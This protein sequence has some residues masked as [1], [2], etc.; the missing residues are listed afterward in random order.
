M[1]PQVFRTQ[2]LV[3]PLHHELFLLYTIL[4]FLSSNTI[5][6]TSAQASNRSESD[7]QALLCFK[8]GISKGSARVL[9]SWRNDSLNFC[10]WRGVTCSTTLPIR[11]VSL[12]LRSTLLTGTLSS[13][14]AALN[15][16][17]QLD[18]WNN[19]L[20][21]SVPEEIG[22]LRSLQ[23]LMLAGNRLSGNI[24]LSL[25][26]AASL[27]SVNLAN[28]SLSGA[29]P[30]S[31]ANSS[32]LSEIILSR[33]N[34]SGG[35]P[36]NLF[37]SS[38]LAAVDLRSNALSGAIP[39]FQKTSALQFLDLTG[40][41]L[42]GTIPASLGNASSLRSLLLAQNKLA[43][44]IP[45]TIGQIP[46]LKRVDLSNNM[47]SGYVPAT[48]YNVSSLTF[49][50]L[51]S[52][53][54]T[55]QLPYDIGHSLP[56][57]ETLAMGLN[58]FRGSVPDSL[59][60]MS[61]LQVLDI[62]S[63]LLTG[64]VPS[65]GSL[66]NLSQLLLGD[67]KLEAD[68]WAFL[69]SLTNCTQL[70]ILSMD[71][72]ILNGSLPKAVGKL[73]TKLQR[74]SF[75]RNQISGNI[76]AEIG[77]LVSLALLDMGRNMLSGPIPLTVWNLS[78][79]VVLKLS[80][81]RLSGQIPS[82]VG[83]LVQ[84]SQLHLD[85]NELSGNI[86]ENIGQCK[87]LLMLNMSVN[88]L[89]GSIPRELFSISSLS[90]GLDLSNNNLTGPIPWEVSNLINLGLLDVS[91]N[92]LSGSLPSELG[93]CVQLL[94]LQI[95]S[96]MLNGSI[97]E[98][99][100]KLKVI[101][102]IDLSENNLT[103]Q[104]P[105]YFVNFS[106]LNYIN[107]SYNKF[108][109]PI[110]TGGIFRNSAAVFLQGNTGLCETAAAI[111]GLPICPTSSATRRKINARLLLIIAPPI[112]IAVISLLC[113]V[114]TIT[115][116]TKAQPSESFKETMRRVSYGDILKATNWFSL[117]NRISSS[118]TASVYI[119]RF[120]FETDL[121]AI[122]VFHLSEQG[123]RNSFFTECEVLKHTRHRNLVQAITLCSTVDF[124][125]EE[126]K[127]IVY[128]FMANGSLDMWIHP[129]VGSSRRLLSLGQRI[130]IA[131]DVASAL[132]YMHN[133]LTPPLIHCDL[134]PGN[135]L[136]DYDM[137]SRIGDFGSTKFLSSSSGGPEGLI[138]VGGTIGY[139]APEYGMGCKIS[140]AGDVY[141]FGVL[142][143]E[144][145]TARRPTDALCGNALSL[146]KYVDLAFP[147]RIAEVLDPHMPSEEDEA[148]ASL[149]VQKYIIP[150]VSIGLMCTMESP[151]DRPGMHDVCAKIVAIKE[152][153]VET[154]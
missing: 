145:L 3:P 43:G 66:A 107:I 71:G 144:M 1:A 49:F 141:G 152:A 136:L 33:N 76:P 65:L 92:R 143:L 87:R 147:D 47:F 46:N 34:L 15:S 90:L 63:N 113:V 128:E 96:N 7:R 11:V 123:S 149:R 24:P 148:A 45:E 55:G 112:T 67:N 103:G 138:G 133:Q 74:L 134:K 21:G 99:F 20:S 18:L 32:S 126:L 78:N 120:E 70:L 58:K 108:E 150:L 60:N 27:R 61:K 59:T 105:Q 142:L 64:V 44:S 104:V 69:T 73:S 91:N 98:S 94:S 154:L 119:G 25:G 29:I 40:N 117:V 83:N 130:S 106:S 35:I 122:K 135:V 89:N 75:G 19:K 51:G 57:L 102:Q 68:D 93:L 52:N 146:H 129:R 95:R 4:I 121:V 151:K 38:K 97:P 6:F 50:S 12:Q 30:D 31:L 118:H 13:C 124:E 54:F 9:G 36:A 137:T 41:S 8:S 77:K 48:L 37:N 10:G 81:N 153:F 125:G 111:F 132:D 115:K 88:H 139:I 127:A 109:G 116:G 80:M 56:N 28:N 62:S 26:T 39:H 72:N 23:T 82:T 140:T 101:Q 16:L 85:D 84:L 131:A 100:S 79:L 42:S 14:M 110:P 5:V 17:V 86:P 114:V 22:E 53:K 2:S